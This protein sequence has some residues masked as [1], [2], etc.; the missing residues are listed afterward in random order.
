MSDIGPVRCCGRSIVFNIPQYAMWS[1]V[2]DVPGILKKTTPSMPYQTGFGGC[3][4]IYV[5]AMYGEYGGRL[6]DFI[7]AFPKMPPFWY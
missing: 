4:E 5:W 3:A 7:T 1:Q 6:V 2:F